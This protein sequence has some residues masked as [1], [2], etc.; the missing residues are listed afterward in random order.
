M[1]IDLTVAQDDKGFYHMFYAPSFSGLEKGQTVNDESGRRYT[2]VDSAA[3]NPEIHDDFLRL[4]FSA[5]CAEQPIRRL[6]GKYVYEEFEYK[7]GDWH[8]QV[9]EG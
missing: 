6:K 9:T 7:E 1:Y 2:V 5:T 4:I 3:L 8:G